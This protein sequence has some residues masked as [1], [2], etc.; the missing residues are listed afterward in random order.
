[1]D[2]LRPRS[3]WGFR[4]EE[5]RSWQGSQS[6]ARREEDFVCAC[7]ELFWLPLHCSLPPGTGTA[8]ATAVQPGLPLGE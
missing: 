8:A 4:G 5:L 2:L 7:V 3:W 1:M 6:A